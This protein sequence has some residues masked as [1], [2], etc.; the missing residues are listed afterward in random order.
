MVSDEKLRDS[1]HAIEVPRFRSDLVVWWRQHGRTF[2]WRRRLPL[3]KALLTEVMLQRTRA[4]QVVAAFRSLNRRYRKAVDLNRMTR[5][6]ANRLF[7]RLGL[8]WRAPLFLEL[9][10]EL[11]RRNGRIK[12]DTKELQGLPAVGLYTAAAAVSLHGGARAV[13]IDSNT[14]RIVC[15]LA[16]IE[17]G[18]ETRRKRW[19]KDALEKLTPDSGFREFNYGLLD[20]GAMVCRPRN[21]ECGVCP[22]SEHCVTGRA[23][24][25]AEGT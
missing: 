23:A 12:R 10:H 6:D 4:D 2:P 3:W 21:P 18:S 20:L 9:A 17:S 25:T 8:A 14:V 13:I 1:I 16:G 22:V 7:A 19:V 24:A 5:N 11:G 15:R